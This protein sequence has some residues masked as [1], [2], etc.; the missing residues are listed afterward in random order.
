MSNANSNN[1]LIEFEDLDINQLEENL[2]QQLE[3]AFSD[4]EFT[5]Q[6]RK[7]IGNADSL[8]EVIRD[9]VWKQFANQIGL[10]ITNETLIQKYDREHPET[11]DE[12]GKKVMQDPNYKKANKEMKEKQNSGTLV[13]EYTGKVIKQSESAN[14]DHTVSRKEIYENSRR[15]QAG[16][17]TEELANKKENL[18]PTNEALN[19]SKGAKSVDEYLENR[20]QKENKLKEQNERCKRKIDE[21]DM[22]DADKRVAKEKAD[23][24]LQDKLDAD[25]EKMKAADK[26]ARSAINRDIATGA[27]KE[28][29]KKAGQDAL[30]TMAVSALMELL[31]EVMNGFVRFMKESS[32]SFKSF[33]NK[34]RESVKSFISKITDFVKTGATSAVGTVVSE[35]F[36]PIVSLFN[37]LASL[38]KQGVSSIISAVKFLADPKNKNMPLSLKVAEVG[39]IFVAMLTA[40]GALALG[41]VFEKA[42]MQIPA[43]LIKIPLLGT[44]ANIIGIFLASLVSGLIG[45][46]ILNLI[47]RFISKKLKANNTAMVIE[48]KNEILQLQDKKIYVSDAVLENT[49]AGAARNIIQNHMELNNIFEQA[50]KEINNSSDIEKL[51]KILTDSRDEDFEEMQKNLEDLF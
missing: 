14:L 3:N 51:N 47:D 7:K 40:T 20:E 37:K 18:N 4:L 25:S 1:N 32:K 11:Y 26:K 15:K 17:S 21:S 34:M 38:I 50:E 19:K 39:K 33:I 46:I 8:G 36:G 2:S 24:S 5:E 49:K 16:L 42:L 41:E 48:K 23:K 35:I 22:S 6:E 13:D 29:T 10:D 31:K 12:V 27:V 9:E 43:M 30:K 45:A 28:V 44:L